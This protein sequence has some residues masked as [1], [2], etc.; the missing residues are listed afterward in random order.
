MDKKSYN[1]HRKRLRDRYLLSGIDG[2]LPHEI[3]E[4]ILDSAIPRSN[5]NPLAK[6]LIDIFGSVNGVMNATV[7]ELC[8]VPGIGEK[9]AIQLKIHKDIANYLNYE[10]IPKTDALTSISQ[11]I[12]YLNLNLKGKINE[13]F[14][15]IYLNNSNSVIK[16]KAVSKGSVNEAKVYVSNIIREALNNGASGLILVHNHPGGSLK[17]SQSDIDITAKIKKAASYFNIRVLDHFIITNDNYFSF[18]GDNL[19]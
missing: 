15:V 14:V 8:N 10:K 3:L 17:P 13:E 7:K 2:F 1:G 4:M 6:E 16:L 12:D 11:V 5:N 9:S 19:L 18:A